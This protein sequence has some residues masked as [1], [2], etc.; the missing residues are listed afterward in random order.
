MSAALQHAQM[1][2]LRLH[3]HI[4]LQLVAFSWSLIDIVQGC[5]R[6]EFQEGWCGCQ[7]ERPVQ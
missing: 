1:A 7:H 4:K 6:V 2:L 5:F 3:M